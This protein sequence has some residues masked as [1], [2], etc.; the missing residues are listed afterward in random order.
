MSLRR[1]VKQQAKAAL[2]G[3]RGTAVAMLLVTLCIVLCLRLL[4]AATL[5]LLGY[6]FEFVWIDAFVYSTDFFYNLPALA[7]S[8]INTLAWLI[9][10]APPLYGIVNWHLQLTEQKPQGVSYLFWPYEQKLGLRAVCLFLNIALRVA[11]VGA[12]LA[13]PSFGAYLLAGYWPEMAYGVVL[14]GDFWLLPT[15]LLTLAF[16]K[17]YAMAPLLIGEKY[18]MTAGE[19]RRLSV[20]YTRGHRWALVGLDLSFLPWALPTLILGTAAIYNSYAYYDYFYYDQVVLLLFLTMTVGLVTWL[21]VQPY[22]SMSRVIY[23]RYLYEAAIY[24]DPTGPTTMPSE[25]E[26]SASTPASKDSDT[27]HWR[28]IPD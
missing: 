11:A 13:L 3:K 23:C 21:A 6:Q 20:R 4:D 28:D 14:L 5:A 25:E 18:A 17:R 10:V 24:S 7:V 27:V 2:R 15:A 19:A 16:A 12:L 8:A 22:M 26:A 1:I 9:L